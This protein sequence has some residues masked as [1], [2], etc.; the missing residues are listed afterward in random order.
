MLSDEGADIVYP[1]AARI[2]VSVPFLYGE[3][4]DGLVRDLHNPGCKVSTNCTEVLFSWVELYYRADEV[5]AHEYVYVAAV[6]TS[7]L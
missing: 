7:T 5:G 1:L 2:G 6:V 3:A 4:S